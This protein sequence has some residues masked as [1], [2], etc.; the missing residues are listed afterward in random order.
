MWSEMISDTTSI[1]KYLP[2]IIPDQGALPEIDFLLGPNTG[3][4]DQ[5]HNRCH[6]LSALVQCAVACV[7]KIKYLIFQ[8]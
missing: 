8:P 1:G 6:S 7:D 5:H 2:E 4:Q 3:T